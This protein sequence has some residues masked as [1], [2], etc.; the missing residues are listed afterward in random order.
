[1]TENAQSKGSPFFSLFHRKKKVNGAVSSDNLK[2]ASSSPVKKEDKYL[3]NKEN[4]KNELSHTLPIIDAKRSSKKSSKGRKDLGK[5][6]SMDVLLE[7]DAAVLVEAL[8][9]IGDEKPI[10]A[11]SIP[12][13]AKIVKKED[14]SLKNCLF[15]Q[16]VYDTMLSD[17]LRV[18]EMLQSHLDDCMV[19]VRAK[20][21]DPCTTHSIDGRDSG[22]GASS[23]SS[24]MSTSPTV[25]RSVKP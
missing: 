10:V 19:S 21:P 9:A 4:K 20:S 13:H 22:R 1:M 16:E 5:S 18:C 8:E 7:G 2:S 6:V 24:T 17:S 11:R 25:K 23:P 3:N 14:N 12:K 15:E